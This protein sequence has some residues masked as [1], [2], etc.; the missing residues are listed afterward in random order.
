MNDSQPAVVQEILANRD[1]VMTLEGSAGTG[2]TTAL[3]AVRD[4]AEREGYHIEGRGGDAG[5][6]PA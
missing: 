4:A 1:Q 2:K 5:T 6:K 3:T